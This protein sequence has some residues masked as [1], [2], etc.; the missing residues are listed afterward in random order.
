MEVSIFGE[1][2][3]TQQIEV[4]IPHP[5]IDGPDQVMLYVGQ[6]YDNQLTATDGA[7]NDI[8][9]SLTPDMVVAT[10]TVGNYKVIYS[11]IYWV[12]LC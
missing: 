5:T 1:D 3:L 12:Y 9:S 6:S 4:Y 7:G 11:G 10:N 8:S 2:S